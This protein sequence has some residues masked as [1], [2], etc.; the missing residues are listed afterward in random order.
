M[1]WIVC[2]WFAMAGDANQ[3]GEGRGRRARREA[4]VGT[5]EDGRVSEEPA[6]ATDPAGL[7][8]AAPQEVKQGLGGPTADADLPAEKPPY[9]VIEITKSPGPES[10]LAV[11]VPVA[12]R[13]SPVPPVI[14]AIAGGLPGSCARP[15]WRRTGSPGRPD[16]GSAA[17]VAA[18]WHTT[19]ESNSGVRALLDGHVSQSHLHRGTSLT[20][21]MEGMPT[22]C[23]DGEWA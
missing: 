8:W 17:T 22:R 15:G 16:S 23:E 7:D 21:C 18:G 3:P 11:T 10:T 14:G 20:A 4:V 12:P 1:R 5:D 19:R 6:A 13:N 9:L 2:G